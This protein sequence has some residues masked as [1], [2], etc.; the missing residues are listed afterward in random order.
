MLNEDVDS[1]LRCIDT[2]TS[3]ALEALEG[4]GDPGEAAQWVIRIRK[5]VFDFMISN[6]EEGDEG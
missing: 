2:C 5:A 1:L 3:R 4:D 6:A